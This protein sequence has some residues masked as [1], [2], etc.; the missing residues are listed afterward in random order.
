M[1][2]SSGDRTDYQPTTFH[3]KTGY[4]EYVCE[5]YS[6]PVT[7]PNSNVTLNGLDVGKSKGDAVFITDFEDYSICSDEDFSE[8]IHQVPRALQEKLDSQWV[9]VTHILPTLRK[10]ITRNELYNQAMSGKILAYQY[11][12]CSVAGCECVYFGYIPA[13]GSKYIAGCHKRCLIAS[14]KVWPRRL[15]VKLSNRTACSC[16]ERDCARWYS[17]FLSDSF[18]SETSF[19]RF[20]NCIR[21]FPWSDI[22]VY[23]GEKNRAFNE[24]IKTPR[25]CK[26]CAQCFA[27]S[28]SDS[29]CRTHTVCKHKR[30]T[31]Y[32]S[33]TTFAK[34]SNIQLRTR[35]K[36]EEGGVERHSTEEPSSSQLKTPTIKPCKRI[37]RSNESAVSDGIVEAKRQRHYGKM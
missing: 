24:R 25:E 10:T 23:P 37:M 22:R 21:R 9:Y 13:N 7:L 36:I 15:L 31:L 20:N 11:T 14:Q 19:V 30:H 33:I 35:R 26:V 3:T 5:K 17:S 8:Y 4:H 2:G 12:E 29:Y 32:N 27:C 1:D 28:R 6:S 18:S 16:G 34:E